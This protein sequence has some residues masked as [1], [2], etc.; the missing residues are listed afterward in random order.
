MMATKSVEADRNK[1]RAME[2]ARRAG[3]EGDEIGVVAHTMLA[4]GRISSEQAVF[5]LRRIDSMNRG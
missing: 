1:L 3:A 2:L 5:E 4:K